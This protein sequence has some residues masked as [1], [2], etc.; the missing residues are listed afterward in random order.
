MS[1]YSMAPPSVDY[2][3]SHVPVCRTDNDKK[4]SVGR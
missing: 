3:N 2:G 4:S 1:C